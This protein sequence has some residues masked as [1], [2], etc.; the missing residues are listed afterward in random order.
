MI[1]TRKNA[2]NYRNLGLKILLQEYVG[3]ETD[4]FKIAEYFNGKEEL[5][6]LACPIMEHTCCHGF[7]G[8]LCEERAFRLGSYLFLVV[9]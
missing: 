6:T 4:R 3:D 7:T 9:K 2:I 8:A 1:A 5:K